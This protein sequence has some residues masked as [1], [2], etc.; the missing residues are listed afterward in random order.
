M[1]DVE[2]FGALAVALRHRGFLV[3]LDDVGAGHSNLDRIPLIRPTSSESI[4]A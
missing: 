1:D 2:R 3:V 4:A